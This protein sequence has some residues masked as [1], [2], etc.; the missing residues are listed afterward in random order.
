MHSYMN[1]MTGT[2]DAVLH[3]KKQQDAEVALTGQTGD[4]VNVIFYAK[5][6][7]NSFSGI[8]FRPVLS[9]IP[10]YI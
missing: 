8:E 3:N 5:L 6:H 2:R 7:S 10:V 1:E 4:L 9:I